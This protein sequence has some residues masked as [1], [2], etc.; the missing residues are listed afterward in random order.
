MVAFFWLEG[1]TQ[2]HTARAARINNGKT[3]V[4]WWRKC[5]EVAVQVCIGLSEPIG[6][7]G[8]VVEIDESMFG[9]SKSIQLLFPFMNNHSVPFK[10]N[11]TGGKGVMVCGFSAEWK[12]EQAGVLWYL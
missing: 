2:E 9:K 10:G 1:H 11:T 7:P 8:V 4:Q 5:R 6:G 12:G 3:L